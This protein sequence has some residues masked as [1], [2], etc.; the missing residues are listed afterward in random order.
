MAIQPGWGRSS[1]I[2]PYKDQF[3][4]YWSMKARKHL[5]HVWWLESQRPHVFLSLFAEEIMEMFSGQDQPPRHCN[6][7]PDIG[8]KASES[9][10]VELP[11]LIKLPSML[12]TSCYFKGHRNNVW[13]M[14]HISRSRVILRVG[15]KKQASWNFLVHFYMYKKRVL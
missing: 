5:L 2:G 15:G 9:E 13:T 8:G 1:W 3:Q 11:M 6:Q 4:E 12:I 7:D 14:V 10:V